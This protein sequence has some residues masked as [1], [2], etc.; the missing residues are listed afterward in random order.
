MFVD[1]SVCTAILSMAFGYAIE[2]PRE[3]FEGL[4]L[5]CILY[6]LNILFAFSF[7][8]YVFSQINS[9][10]WCIFFGRALGKTSRILLVQD[11]SC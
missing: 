4:V 9:V 5:D 11:I 2:G 10:G 1:Y 7:K 6:C 3:S 8:K